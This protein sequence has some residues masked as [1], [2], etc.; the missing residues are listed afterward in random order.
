M[1]HIVNNI[2]TFQARLCINNTDPRL[3]C[4]PLDIATFEVRGPNP[5]RLRDA[6]DAANLSSLLTG[7]TFDTTVTDPPFTPGISNN[8]PNTCS[9]LIDLVVPLKVSKNGRVT[10]ANRVIK[11]RG[12]TTA[13]RKDADSLK[14]ECRPT[15]C[16]NGVI[17]DDH[18]TCDDSN[19]INGDGCN[20]AC[21]VEVNPPPT[22]TPPAPR[23]SRRP[24]RRR[25]TRPTPPPSL[26]PPAPRRRRPRRRRS[27]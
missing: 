14:L 22:A 10:R 7:A 12:T 5:T 19:R 23:A 2:C 26:Q 16:G 15:T 25:Y 11:V 18:E 3:P 8:V 4:T 24:R 27:R 21:Q 17:E 13:G 20:Q 9:D 1:D 6:A